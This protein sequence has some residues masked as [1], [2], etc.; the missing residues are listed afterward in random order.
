MTE[1][2][3]D[4]HGPLDVAVCVQDALLSPATCTM[5]SAVLQTNRPAVAQFKEQFTRMAAIVIEDAPQLLQAF[6]VSVQASLVM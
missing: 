2:I 5:L 4:L 3:A 1:C 6:A